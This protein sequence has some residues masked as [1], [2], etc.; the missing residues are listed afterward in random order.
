MI[1]FKL[2]ITIRKIVNTRCRIYAGIV[3][4]NSTPKTE[5][6]QN[7]MYVFSISEPDLQWVLE[8]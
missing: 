7:W 8:S 6:G 2:D 3:Y 4:E 1:V 5:D